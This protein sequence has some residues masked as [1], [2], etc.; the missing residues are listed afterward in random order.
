MYSLA[1]HAGMAY[2]PSTQNG[3]LSVTRAGTSRPYT[4]KA[5]VSCDSLPSRETL[6]SWLAQARLV[7]DG[8]M[9]YTLML[10]IS[11]PVTHHGPQR[12]LSR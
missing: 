1:D 5:F 3:T 2:R 12:A 4:E 9:Q 10:G 7:K 8:L 6:Q 11:V